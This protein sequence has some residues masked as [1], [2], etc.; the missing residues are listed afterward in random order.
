VTFGE[1]LAG[2]DG[3]EA[4]EA[5]E[6]GAELFAEEAEEFAA[7]GGGNVAP[8]EVGGVGLGDGRVRCFRGYRRELRDDFA[9]DGRSDSEVA[10]GIGGGR[11]AEFGEDGLDFLF[12]SHSVWASVDG[13][14]YG[15]Q[16]VGFFGGTPLPP[17]WG[18]LGVK[19]LSSMV[20]SM[21]VSAKYS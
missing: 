19:Y 17:S 8:L 20:Y 3:D 21:V 9:G 16:G 12:D 2:L 10:V 15:W 7:L 1:E 14:G 13:A 5:G 18:I 6:F 4:T 11:D